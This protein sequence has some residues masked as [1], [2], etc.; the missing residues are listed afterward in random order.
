MNCKLF[1]TYKTRII[2]MKNFFSQLITN[3]CTEMDKYHFDQ[4]CLCDNLLKT[5]DV[6]I[7]CKKMIIK[8][9]KPTDERIKFVNSNIDMP[10]DSREYLEFFITDGYLNRHSEDN[11]YVSQYLLIKQQ[12][13]EDYEHIYLVDVNGEPMDVRMFM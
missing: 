11:G 10:L 1:E 2:A 13:L 3:E 6:L 7:E 12:F 9:L 4:C 8:T 5:I